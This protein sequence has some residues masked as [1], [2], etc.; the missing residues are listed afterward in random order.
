MTRVEPADVGASGHGERC[1]FIRVETPS[2]IDVVVDPWR[3]LHTIGYAEWLF[4]SLPG[5]IH[6]GKLEERAVRE[7][8]MVVY[9][10]QPGFAEPV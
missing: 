8:Y 7:L 6:R 9:M 4:D 10:D 5:K 1:T 2:Y 3:Y